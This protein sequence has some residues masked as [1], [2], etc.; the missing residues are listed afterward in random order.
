MEEKL[1]EGIKHLQINSESAERIIAEYMRFKYIE[2][3]TDIG[4][5]IFLVAAIIFIVFL[6][7][8]HF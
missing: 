6:M 5:A 1:L 7:I 4:L 2:L 8:K 3:W